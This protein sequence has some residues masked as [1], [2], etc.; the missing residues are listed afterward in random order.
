M[1][2]R[3]PEAV[4]YAEL[5]EL[6]RDQPH[7][8]GHMVGY[9]KLTEIHSQ[10]IWEAWGSPGV[11]PIPVQ[12]HRGSYKTTGITVIGPVWWHLFHP[13]DRIAIVRESW[14]VSKET[15]KSIGRC[16]LTEPIQALFQY[17][18]KRPLKLTTNKDGQIIT[19][20]KTSITKEGSFDA[21]GITQVP[22]G[23]HY[24]VII[25][26]DIITKQDRFSKAKREQTKEGLKEVLTNIIDPG[27]L[28]VITGTPWHEDD[29]WNT[30]N[31]RGEN[32]LKPPKK[33]DCYSTGVLTLQE[34]ENKKSL[35]TQSL[36]D[37]NYLLKHTSDEQ[38]IFSDPLFG[39]WDHSMHT[40]YYHAHLDAAFGGN[41]T[42]ALTLGA[43]RP[44]GKIQI[45]GK[46]FH[47]HIDDKL[48][49]LFPYLIR[50][51]CTKIH[52][53]TNPDKGFLAKKLA[54]RVNNMKLFP[55]PYAE[56]MNKHNKIITYVK[57]YWHELIFDPETD[58]EYMAQ[59]LDYKEGAEPNDAAD[60]LASF[61]RQV[62]YP[63][64]NKQSNTSSLYDFE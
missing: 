27:K 39:P 26:D 64:D 29:A 19:N 59:I 43:R 11:D 16:L 15:L 12:G 51:R 46:T 2:V 28:C 1:V 18:H 3:V 48:E 55:K 60:S 25:M 33:Y 41:C 61:L 54:V 24:D 42:N 34:I 6:V 14:T 40:K 45:H 62:F 50:R 35:T 30:K 47:E 31:A 4:N 13:N 36:F 7:L 32:I 38:R 5:L 58:P 20:L 22:T 52:L 44:D 8:L 37:A 9:D 17:A 10:M 23:S 63:A 49:W 56:S 57:A 21:H 53:E